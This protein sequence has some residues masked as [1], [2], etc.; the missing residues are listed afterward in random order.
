MKKINLKKSPAVKTMP[1]DFTL[2]K[3][4][5]LCCAVAQHYPTLTLSEY[6]Q[7]KDMPTRFAMMRHDID[8]KP[9]NALFTAR[10][11]EEAGIRATYYFR[12]YGSA[13]RPEIIR[14]IEG[15][16][17]EVGYHYEVLGKAKGDRERAIGMFEHELGEFREICDAVFDL[18]KSNDK[19]I[20]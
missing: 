19:V 11:E 2:T 16:G 13:F 14:E 9:E 17:H 1:L 10:V 12:R 8:R 3:F 15:M 5:S 4:R 20:K 7:G 18:Q 6:F